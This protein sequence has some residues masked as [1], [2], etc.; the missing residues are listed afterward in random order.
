MFPDS[1]TPYPSCPI[2]KYHRRARKSEAL[3]K[4]ADRRAPRVLAT[5]QTIRPAKLFTAIIHG[6]LRFIYGF[7]DQFGADQHEP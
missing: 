3:L 4:P 1:L 2:V 7:F 6:V 5:P